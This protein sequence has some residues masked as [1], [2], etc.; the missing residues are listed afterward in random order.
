MKKLILSKLHIRDF[1]KI[2]DL[3]IDFD[4]QQTTIAGTNG[5]GKSTIFDAYTWLLY[6]KNSHDQQDFSIKRLDSD[7]KVIHNL[8]ASVRGVF[9]LDSDVIQLERRYKEKWTKKRGNEHEELTGHT[10]EYFIDQIPKSKGEF[11]TYVKGM[12]SD[13]I[14]KVISSPLYFNEKM[15]WQERREILT[16]IAGDTTPEDVLNFAPNEFKSANELLALL[17]ARKSLTDEKTRIASERKR[18]K[19]QLDGIAPKIEELTSMTVT[20]LDATEL[21]A[22]KAELNAAKEQINKQLD[23]IAEQNK[24]EQQKV[25]DSNNQL[26]KWQDEYTKAKRELLKDHNDRAQAY[27]KRKAE[28]RLEIQKSE[29]LL[30][31]NGSAENQNEANLRVLTNLQAKLKEKYETEKAKEFTAI[32]ENCPC[33]QRPMESNEQEQLEKFNLAKAN[34]I[35]QIVAEAQD[36]KI[37]MT[38]CVAVLDACTKKQADLA[39]QLTAKETYLKEVEASFVIE[40]EPS[41]TPDMLALKRAIDTYKPYTPEAVCNNALKQEREQLDEQ[42]KEVEASLAKLSHIADINIRIAELSENKRALAQQIASLERVAFQID[43]YEK[44]HIELVESRVN[45]KFAIV[46]WKMFD[47]QINGGLAPTCE[48]TVNGTPYNDLNTAMKIN[49]GLDV[50]NALNYHFGMFAPVFIDARESIVEI[51]ETECQVISLQ[52]DKSFSELTVIM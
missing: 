32:A 10:T 4:L 17:E 52:V 46:K 47:E 5:V 38:E 11:D 1:K 34:A 14:A 19:E 25:I 51:I 27:E 18:L 3:E 41:D 9:I 35:K 26:Y 33:C 7:G 44:A 49:A 48:A 37:K 31:E 8:V 20:E 29:F 2:N 45:A 24:A 39:A 12:I 42:I 43:A 23:D 28:L 21:D 15:K 50:I 22:K 40:Q 30:S 16:S 36:V 6:G 13:T